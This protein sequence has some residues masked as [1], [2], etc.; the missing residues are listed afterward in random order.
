MLNTAAQFATIGIP[1]D[2]QPVLARHA[3]PGQDPAGLHLPLF[4]HR[5]DAAASSDA[6]RI[7]FA[8]TP[9]HRQHLRRARAGVCRLCDGHAALRLGSIVG[10][11]RVEHLKNRGIARRDGRRDGTGRS[12]AKT[13]QTLAFPSLH[14]NYD[15]DD[16][17]KLR[18]SFNSGAARAGLRP[19]AAQRTCQRHQPDDLGRQPRG[20]ARARLR[21][22]RLFRMVHAAA[23][24]PVARRVLQEGQGRAVPTPRTF[25]SDVL[26]H[27]RHR[28]LG[29]Y[30]LRHHQRRRR[31]LFGVE[32][33]AQ[34][35]LEPFTPT[36]ACPTGSSAASA[37][38]PT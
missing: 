34:L 21:R 38:R 14:F 20:E 16:T 26:E 31:A 11:V 18:L 7:A 3:V 15:V 28:P 10:G 5:Q 9:A 30:L 1:T 2:Y 22:R 4:R 24:L 19:A 35:Q 23:G 6:A 27:R 33:A 32:A 29:L 12:T 13:D 25:G 37:S 36:S 17:K 8:F